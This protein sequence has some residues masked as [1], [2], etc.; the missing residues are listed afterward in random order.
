MD[1]KPHLG[2]DKLVRILQNMRKDLLSQGTEFLFNSTVIDIVLNESDNMKSK[3]ITG[4]RLAN[5]S[6]I[7]S[8]CVILA[9]GHSSRAMYE[10]LMSKGVT[11]EPKGI[12]VGF[13]VEHPQ[14]LINSI[15]YGNFSE[16]CLRGKGTIPVADYRLTADVSSTS[17]GKITST[18]V[19]FGIGG[20]DID[21][22]EMKD[23]NDF[24]A[25]EIGN[26]DGGDRSRSCYSF[27]M[28]PGGQIGTHL[29]YPLVS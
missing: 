10:C 9:V 29:R 13:R 21:N 4:V 19:M 26:Q 2:T 24:S 11:I 28:C 8:D 15:Q 18:R 25:S 17:R 16:L 14:E 3:Q 5:G 22:K 23:Y 1:G 27:C 12:A 6:V 20:D 7:S